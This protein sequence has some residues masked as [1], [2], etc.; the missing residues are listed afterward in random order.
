MVNEFKQA[1]D[2]RYQAVE[3]EKKQ[4]K[5]AIGWVCTYVPEEILYAA[6]MNPVRILGAEGETPLAD[7]HMYSNLCTFVRSSL[8]M[9]LEGKYSFLDGYVTCNTCDHIRRQFDVWERYIDTS[10]THI[11]SL[12]HKITDASQKYFHTELIRLKEE[13]QKATGKEITED[14]LNEAIKAYNQS[15][16]LLQKIDELRKQEAPPIT[17]AESLDIALTGMVIPREQ[18]NQMLERFLADL[19]NRKGINGDRLRIMI[20]GSE[21][22]HSEYVKVIED[23]GSI[24]VAEDICCASRYIGD[25]VPTDGNPM[26]ALADRYLNKAQCPRMRPPTER[27]ARIKDMLKEYK[28]DGIIYQVIKFCNLIGEDY[29]ILRNAIKDLDIPILVLN[30]EYSVAGL[31]QMKTRVQAFFESIQG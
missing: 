13:L 11:I 22:D 28:I 3:A 30:R 15:R 23:L 29:P 6:G 18:Y 14:S 17:G 25:L 27:H 19:E 5:K 21:L 20:A 10:F 16:V 9:G 2:N 31:G 1:Y 4:G 8:Q 12:P 26:E 24:V 7:A